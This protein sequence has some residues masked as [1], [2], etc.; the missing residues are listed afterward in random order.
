LFSAERRWKRQL[1]A[2]P[3]TPIGQA[4]SG[5]IKIA[6]QLAFAYPPLQAP[7][8]GRACAVYR[9]RVEER[10]KN[11][12]VPVIDEINGQ[13][14]FLYDGSGRALI[15]YDPQTAIVLREDVQLVSQTLQNPTPPMVALLGRYGV[16]PQRVLGLNKAIRYYEG[17]LEQGELVT[18]HGAAFREPEPDP[19]AAAAAGLPPQWLVMRAIQGVELRITDDAPPETAAPPR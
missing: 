16:N 7:L 1:A 9:V 10:Q 5:T 19:A 2:M 8:S 14:F 13:P 11:R 12:W 15:A 17:A 6:G 18:V 3:R 4:A